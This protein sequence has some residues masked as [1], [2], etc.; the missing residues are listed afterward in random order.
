[1]SA[2]RKTLS[3]IWDYLALTLGTLLYCAAWD[4][5][6]IP[7][8]IASGGLTGACTILEFATGIPV[9]GSFLVANVFLL[10]LSVLVMGK[11]FGFRTLYCIGLSTLLF[12]VLPRF[13]QFASL[14]GHF[15]YVDTPLLVPV[16]G[17]L[18]EAI[19]IGLILLKGGSTGGTDIVAMIVNKFW[20]VSPGR[21][22]LFLD[23]FIIATTLLLPASHF[24]A[25]GS[26]PFTIVVYGYLCMITFSFMVDVVLLGR[27][28][29][30][31]VMVFSEHYER[32]ADYILNRLDR[33]VTVLKATGWYTRSDR[34]VLLI[35]VRKNQLHEV[36]KAIKEIDHKAFVSVSPA[37]GVYGEGFDEMKTGIKL[38]KQ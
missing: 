38:K 6:L 11:S 10:V 32:I 27:R 20:P 29:T 8:H 26:N 4:Y 1:M 3:I 25:A 14:P 16:I 36:T 22:Y 31:Q 23:L 2:L 13:D 19:G 30:A 17:G 5:F 18:L 15:F 35:I 9:S 34:N 21:V 12:A 37:S 7:N 28:S 33:G 24:E